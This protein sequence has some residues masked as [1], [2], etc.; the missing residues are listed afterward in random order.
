MSPSIYSKYN[1]ASGSIYSEPHLTEQH[2]AEIHADLK[3]AGVKYCVGNYVDIHGVPKGKFVPLSHFPEFAR[4]SELYTGYALD[5]LGQRPNDDEIASVPDLGHIIPL[6]WNP[7][8]AWM[9]ADNTLH[10]APYEVSTRVALQKVLQQAEAMGFGMNLGIECE[11]FVLK[12]TEDGRLEIPNDDDNLNKSC[13]DFKRFM[14]RYQWVDKMATT[15][16]AL[17]WELYSLD[18]EDANS[19]FEFD[20]KYA[21]A[22]T[23]CDRY[24]FF[25]R[26]P[27]TTR[28]KKA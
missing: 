5:G 17:G 7:E 15:I 21:D 4:G 12:R 3:E 20:F 28:R 26:W 2:I 22:L 14:D 11:V 8:V 6:P 9:P 19:Q 16:D 24:I 27:N 13:Y 18:H 25:V 1:K 10:G 23:M